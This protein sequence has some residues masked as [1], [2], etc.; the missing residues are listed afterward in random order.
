[1]RQIME[2]RNEIVDQEDKTSRDE[3]DE[4]SVDKLGDSERQKSGNS[5]IAEQAIEVAKRMQLQRTQKKQEYIHS[6]N[7]SKSTTFTQLEKEKQENF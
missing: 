4:N 2:A 1:M 3:D 7:Q 6:D 5:E